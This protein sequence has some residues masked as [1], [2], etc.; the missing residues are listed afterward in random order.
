MWFKSGTSTLYRRG[1][2][3]LTSSSSSVRRRVW[4]PAGALLPW[5]RLR[6]WE[7]DFQ[8]EH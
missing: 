6:A 2:S 7:R 3:G 8:P 1:K 4:A 5:N